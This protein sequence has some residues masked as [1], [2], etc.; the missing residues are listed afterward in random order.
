M[1]M[2]AMSRVRRWASGSVLKATSDGSEPA[3]SEVETNSS[4]CIP[5]TGQ[6]QKCKLLQLVR[7]AERN[8]GSGTAARGWCASPPCRLPGDGRCETDELLQPL[9]KWFYSQRCQA[10]KP[11]RARD[12]RGFSGRVVRG[13]ACAGMERLR[14]RVNDFSE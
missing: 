6:E 8:T 14:R 11:A 4:N 1:M 12:R 10:A 3:A 5:F 7:F 9:S 13:S 2:T